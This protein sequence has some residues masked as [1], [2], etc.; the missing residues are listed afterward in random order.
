[1]KSKS[2]RGLGRALA[3]GVLGFASLGANSAFAQT[4]TI[5]DRYVET[6]NGPWASTALYILTSAGDIRVSDLSGNGTSDVGDWLT[7]KS[8]MSGYEVRA[9]QGSPACNG[10]SGSWQSLGSANVW[11][12]TAGHPVHYAYCAV[13]LEIRL[14]SNPSVILDSAWITLT[15]IVP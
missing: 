8:G 10:P 4:V 15:A 14:A 2:T 7:P 5:A 9:T 12:V 11:Y 13:F 1:M 6:S 3:L